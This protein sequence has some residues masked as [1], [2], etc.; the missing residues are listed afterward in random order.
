MHL[1]HTH[2]HTHKHTYARSLAQIF[3]CNYGLLTVID[4][5]YVG[6][7]DRQEGP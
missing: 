1:P 5:A 7:W 6:W 3:S 2:T 4:L